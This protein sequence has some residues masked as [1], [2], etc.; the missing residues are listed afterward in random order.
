MQ[1]PRIL[2]AGEVN[3]E[4]VLKTPYLPEPGHTVL[5]SGFRYLPG[6]QG[7]HTSVALARLGAD[8]ILCAR[9]G[10]DGNGRD[11]DEYLAAEGIDVRFLTKA[12]GENTALSVRLQ[13]D[14]SCERRLCFDEAAGKLSDSEIEEA[15][16]CYPDALVLHGDLPP[17]AY[18]KI[19]KINRE[20]NIPVFLLSAPDPSRYPLSRFGS[21]E[22]LILDEEDAYRQTGIRLS[23]Q[24]KCMKA[25]IALTQKIKARYVVLRLG[26]KGSFL[27]DGLYYHFY[28]GYDVPQPAGV[29]GSAAFSA[30][31]VLEYLRSEGDVPRSCEFA[32]IATA[33][34]LTRGGGFPSYPTEDDLLRFIKRNEIAFDLDANP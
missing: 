27:F 4:L 14:Q 32:T 25:C 34:F 20:E 23:D 5:G 24:E 10:D 17:K 21:C 26:E 19:I 11:L 9:V 28:P 12:K 16:I 7:T 1:K 2:T 18:D 22:V 33:V 6:G 15:F 29:S 8:V 3:T 31:L 30:A 13:E